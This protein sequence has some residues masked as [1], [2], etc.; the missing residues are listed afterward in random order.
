MI[1]TIAD[2]KYQVEYVEDATKIANRLNYDA[3]K[4]ITF[5]TETTGLHLKK[6][7]PFLGAVCWSVTFSEVDGI[8]YVFPTTEKNLSY[9]FS[10]W[11]SLTDTVYAHNT[12]FDL[13]MVA[14]IIGDEEVR[15]VKNVGDTMGLCRLIFEAV[16]TR[17][18]GHKLGLKY[19][20]DKFIDPAASIYEKQV[21][22]WLKDKAAADR[23]VLIVVLRSVGWTMTRFEAAMNKGTEEIP[24]DVM[25]AF[26]D[27]RNE[28]PEPTYQDVPMEI[29]L[30]YVAVDVIGTDLLVHKALPVVEQKE[31]LQV[32]KDEFKVI[33]VVFNM[34][35]VGI[36]TDREY[37][38]E[39]GDRL[40]TYMEYLKNKMYDLSGGKEFTVGQHKFISDMYTEILG[41]RPKSTDKKFMTTQANAGT[42]KH[43][44][45]A[46]VISKLRTVDKWKSTYVDR[47]LE[48]SE[49]D[50]RFYA[51]LDQFNPVSGRF[52][53]NMQQQPKKALKFE[54]IE[55]DDEAP[56]E[57]GQELFHPRKA[58]LADADDG[59][60][61][62]LLDFS[63][64]ELRFQAHYTLPFGG[65]INLCRSYMP[66]KCFH[67]SSSE[68]EFDYMTEEG[69]AR[70][71]ERHPA[72]PNMSA[73]I[74][75]ETGEPWT[76]TDVHSASTEKA[77][78]L[79]GIDYATMPEE[80]FQV[81]RGLG[82]GVNFAKNYGV[83][84]NGAAEQFGLD[85]P[86]AKALCNGYDIAFPMVI[87][88][89]NMVSNRMGQRGFVAG[90][91]G[92]RYYLSDS[93]RFYKAGNYLIQGSCAH[94][95]KL[96]MVLIDE[97]LAEYKSSMITC[98]HDEIIYRIH[99]SEMFLIP[100]LKEIMEYTPKVNVPIISEIDYT[101]TN[102]ASKKR[103]V[104]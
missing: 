57:D 26:Y 97:L 56:F 19:L 51:T 94:D 88:Y 27:W 47:I 34:S 83:G 49:Y 89:Q 31:Q 104:V 81:W 103:Y 35:R 10:Y 96:K 60:K 71:D 40:D 61:I 23:K 44:L 30:P 3:P 58:F 74:V 79:M 14:N 100:K 41:E 11:A 5:D 73:W 2:K 17:E 80:D 68:G 62:F 29:M 39:S 8:V 93:R 90:V 50:G 84:V 42:E 45:L 65:D 43:N 24:F 64:V 66:F 53:G 69:K 15:S 87:T 76:K 9:N 77:L 54:L 13:N 28:Y 21:K 4:W 1:I 92:R 55:E 95:L 85:L 32:M 99:E 20:M 22:K 78:G 102:W 86:V 33:P 75:P 18:G 67:W 70:W 37:L 91:Y 6:D 46:K 59:Y 16:S 7:R 98:I 36:K 12:V 63:Q 72:D 101:E 48:G 52:S 82:K 38:M 25:N